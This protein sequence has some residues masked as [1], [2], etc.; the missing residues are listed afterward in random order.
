MIYC[1]WVIVSL[2]LK[3]DMKPEVTPITITRY[4]GSLP[5]RYSILHLGEYANIYHIMMP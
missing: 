2:S 3:L 5:D 4:K 1:L